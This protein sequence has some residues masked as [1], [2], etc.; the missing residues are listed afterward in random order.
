MGEV[1]TLSIVAIAVVL[2]LVFQGMVLASLNKESEESEPESLISEKR[3]VVGAIK[4]LMKKSNDND[5][6]HLYKV[7]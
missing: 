1:I 3:S 7:S 6:M 2:L 5:T 4:R